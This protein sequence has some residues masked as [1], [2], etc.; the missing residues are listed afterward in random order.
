MLKEE[1]DMNSSIHFNEWIEKYMIVIATFFNLIIF[2]LL[3]F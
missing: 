1:N 2:Y 3:T